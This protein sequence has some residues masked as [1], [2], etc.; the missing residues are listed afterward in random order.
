M[1]SYFIFVLIL[2]T[3]A[4]LAQPNFISG[5]VEDGQTHE[6]L[7]GASISIY[8]SAA[9][10]G[11]ISN[12]EGKFTINL[13]PRP[14]SIRFSMIG[15]RSRLLD[16]TSLQQG[17]LIT[18]RLERVPSALQEVVVRPLGVMDIM[19]RAAQRIPSMIPA[20]DYESQAFY[21]EII[22]DSLRYYSVAE[23]IFSIQFSPQKKSFKLKLDKGRSKEDVACT[24][25]F[26]DYHPG[27]GP[28]DAV[29]QSPIISQPDFLRADKFRNYIY[30]KDSTIRED[31]NL[32]YV[33]SFDQKP[34]LNEALEKGKV[35]IE[36]EDFTLVKYEAVNSPLGTAY[37]KSLRGSDKI[38]AEILHID[39]TVRG[40]S[41]TASYTKIGEKLFLSYAK[42]T[43]DID[44]K[45]PKKEIDLRLGIHTEL[46]VTD[47][48]HPIA[49]EI[50]MGEEWKRKNIVANLPSDF[51]S[52]FWGT[53]DILSPTAEIVSI[54]SS[55]SNKNND[56]TANSSFED[57]QF[58]NKGSFSA[59]KNGDS[60]ILV[61]LIKSSWEDNEAR[62]M[63]FQKIEG[64]FSIEARLFL[65]KRSNAG[66]V[67]DN[68]FQQS[69]II[70]RSVAGKAENNLILSIGTGGSDVPKYFLKRTNSGRTRGL[71][72]KMDSLSS[73]LR[74]ERRGKLISAYR[75]P[76]ESSTWMK[77]DDYELD[78]LTGELQT[79]FSTMARFAGDGPK[80]HPDM[81]A[82]FSNIKIDHL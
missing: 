70:V 39:L 13:D 22:R 58:L 81:K 44:Y 30:K 15:Y 19:Q 48:Q 6:A 56:E 45:Q 54:I 40:W 25:L 32:I 21:R 16:M 47:F 65:T 23:A 11:G 2:S 35:Y 46:L 61:P 36:A 73:W 7:T 79:G 4:S 68:G 17:S 75:R 43:Y 5:K 74:I 69:G 8:K 10:R 37:I 42:M 24:R 76:D 29:G 49:K 64:N 57:W 72:E 71:A 18:V 27:G 63:I 33:I 60:I 1:K 31:D 52:A 80:Q 78:W 50:S 12:G 41:R 3:F 38:F 55:L 53:Q 67:P 28:E 20:K 62:G 82:V 34:G 14:D 59:H 26:E 66:F 51:D 77:V 9:V